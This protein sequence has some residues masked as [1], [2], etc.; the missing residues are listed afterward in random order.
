MIVVASC[1]SRSAGE[2][3]G[4][5][6]P[7]ADATIHVQ[8]RIASAEAMLESEKLLAAEARASLDQQRQELEQAVG[9]EESAWMTAEK[10]RMELEAL[11][12]ERKKLEQQASGIQNEIHHAGIAKASG[13]SSHFQSCTNFE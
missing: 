5:D 1:I 8:K 3:D 4:D 10:Q 7:V 2:S 13:S 11:V 12:L 9:L 6:V